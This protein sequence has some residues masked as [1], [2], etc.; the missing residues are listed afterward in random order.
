[1]KNKQW[2]A[3]V[4]AGVLLLAAIGCSSNANQKPG[5]Q[6]A[7]TP[8]A[9]SAQSG[10]QTITIA[11]SEGGT[12]MDPAEASDLTS[13]TLVVAAYDQLVTYGVKN[14]DGGQVANTDEIKPMLAKSW[15][16]SD[17]NLTYTFT[18]QDNAKF[19]SGNPVTADSV[20]YS[21][22]RLSKSKSGSFLYQLSGIK[23]VTVK[24]PKT[25]VIQLDKPNHMFMQMIGL[26]NF[27]I[28]DD[29]LMKEKGND[30]VT[31]HAAG[32]GPF[33]IE[34]W[35]P[36]TEAVLVANKSYW[37]GAPKLDKV[38]L[39]FMKEASNRVMLLGKG[40]VDMAIE[41]PA[42]DVADLKKNDKI[43]V[44]SNASNRIL[45]FALN[46]NV[47]PFDN[48]KVRQALAY[49][50]PYDQLIHDVM[51][52]QAKQMKSAVASNTPGYSDAGYVYKHDLEKAKQLLKEAG[53]EKGFSFDLTLGSGFQDWE[54]D[55]VLMQAEFAKI[56]VTMN[57][58]KV[59]RAQFLQMQKERNLTAYISKWTSFV[60]DPSYHLGFLLYGKGTSNYGNYKNA[61]VDELWEQANN[62]KDKAKRDALYK[63]AQEIITTDSPWL[64]LYEY[65]R[66]V[67]LNKNVKGYVYYPDEIIRFYPISKGQ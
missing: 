66:I 36:A 65:N 45:Y 67:G 54:D 9:P 47:K 20:A 34:K 30:Y 17:D 43:A 48:Q 1:M 63:Q 21:L 14:A 35:D 13:D 61:K 16:V 39:K 10:G 2:L 12:T 52:D 51:Y 15:T 33:S 8:N 26:Y 28:L 56:G 37:Q 49:A 24:D 11:Y 3:S 5:D 27:S 42:K 6:A 50:V 19:Q 58:Q 55:A 18:L 29:K 4:A 57:I 41:I 32:S 64:Y 31:N 23:T 46:T 40:D 44:N 59:A 7:T 53:Y 62:E 38:T 60:N 22:D 25:I